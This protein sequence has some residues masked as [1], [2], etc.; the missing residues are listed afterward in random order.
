MIN[1]Q[2]EKQELLTWPLGMHLIRSKW[3]NTF[4][5]N[6]LLWHFH[7]FLF[8]VC[9][10]PGVCF[11]HHSVLKYQSSMLMLTQL[12]L[13]C[14]F[15]TPLKEYA[16][17]GDDHILLLNFCS[18]TRLLYFAFMTSIKVLN[19]YLMKLRL[20][21]HLPIGFYGCIHSG[22]MKKKAKVNNSR[23]C[24]RRWWAFNDGEPSSHLSRAPEIKETTNRE[25]KWWRN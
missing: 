3:A 2:P 25:L 19:S 4:Q 20:S 17:E 18:Y 10:W 9:L 7:C 13:F 24:H 16:D 22:T 8:L 5:W 14:L 11:L 15:P 21:R 6:Y 23:W 1:G 12:V